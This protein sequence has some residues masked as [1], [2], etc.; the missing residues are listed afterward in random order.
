MRGTRFWLSVGLLTLFAIGTIAA[1]CGSSD[2]SSSTS[3][4]TSASGVAAAISV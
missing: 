4:T 3:T 1:G 2:D